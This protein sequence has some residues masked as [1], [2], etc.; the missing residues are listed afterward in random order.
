M[1]EET[2]GQVIIV[3]ETFVLFAIV[4]NLAYKF[5]IF[6]HRNDEL[7]DF[8]HGLFKECLKGRGTTQ[9]MEEKEIL[10]RLIG[11]LENSR[12]HFDRNDEF[13]KTNSSV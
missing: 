2:D 13:L 11:T 4:E 1:G 8:I 6:T 7:V 9:S 5:N 3:A 10:D 12:N